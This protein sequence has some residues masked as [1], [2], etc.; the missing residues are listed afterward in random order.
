MLHVPVQN[1]SQFPLLVQSMWER[2]PRSATQFP[3]P[4]QLT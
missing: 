4:V 1:A 3:E 2:G